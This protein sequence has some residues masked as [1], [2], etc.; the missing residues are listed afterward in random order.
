MKSRIFLRRIKL[1][2]GI[3]IALFFVKFLSSSIFLA[4]SPKINQ[5]F[6]EDLINY[7]KNFLASASSFFNKIGRFN[8]TNIKKNEP[9]IEK[10]S[11]K[12]N[13]NDS[14]KVEEKENNKQKFSE[15]SFKEI[16]SGVK[17]YEDVGSRTLYIKY[18][19]D[20][21]FEKKIFTNSDGKIV[22]FYVPQGLIN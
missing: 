17:V 8:L 2:L 4:N 9:N 20:V 3:L 5:Y 12:E 18:E 6:L 14:L 21:K 11:F 22:E 7:S 10:I 13:F 16:A 19:E 15:T 1:I